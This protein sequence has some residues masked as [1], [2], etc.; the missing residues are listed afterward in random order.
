MKQY[1]DHEPIKTGGTPS[2]IRSCSTH[3]IHTQFVSILQAKYS[4]LHLAATPRF[5][6]T[7]SFQLVT[8]VLTKIRPFIRLRRRPRALPVDAVG[9][10]AY[11]VER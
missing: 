3:S 10:I 8:T 2:S 7:Y 11:G 5:L 4:A 9:H 6:Y 1:V